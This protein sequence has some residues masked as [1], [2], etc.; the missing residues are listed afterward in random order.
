[1]KA[2]LMIRKEKID[3]SR[4]TLFRQ[5][6]DGIDA[7]KYGLFIQVEHS[8]QYL[9]R[10]IRRTQNEDDGFRQSLILKK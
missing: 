6:K 4:H 7:T 1:M 3:S 8:H 5:V 10:G 2:W 9:E